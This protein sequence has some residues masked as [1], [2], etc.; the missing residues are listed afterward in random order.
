MSEK[1]SIEFKIKVV[2]HALNREKGVSLKDIAKKYGIGVSTLS[3]WLKL[4]R[5]GQLKPEKKP[6]TNEL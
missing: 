1:F 6:L 4:Y 5:T 3:K 2:E